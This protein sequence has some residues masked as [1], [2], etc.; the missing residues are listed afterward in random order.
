MEKL[1]KNYYKIITALGMLLCIL[2]I[3]TINTQPF[4]DF[5]YYDELAKQ[6]ANGGVLGDTYT[7]VGYSIALAFIYKIFGSSLITAKIFNLVL[8]FLNYMMIYSI[9]K[10]LDLHENKRIFIYTLFV[11]FPNNIFYNSIL[12]TEIFFTTIL[13]LVTLIYYSD[14]KYKYLLIGLLTGINTMVKPFFIVFFFV[15][16]IVE[17]AVR[18]RFVEIMKHTIIILIISI[19]TISPWIYRNTKLMGQYTF[20]SNNGGI[21]LYINN[22]SQ[23]HFGRWMPPENIENSLVNKKEYIKANMTEKNKMLSTS[24]KKWIISHPKQFIELGF[25]RLFNTYFFGDDISYSFNG[26]NLNKSYK[27]ILTVYTNNVRRLV[28]I[29]SIVV[30]LVYTIRLI[31]NLFNK[32]NIDSYNAYNLACFYMFACVYF[33]T[34]GQARYAFPSIFIMIYFFSCLVE[35]IAFKAKFYKHML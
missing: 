19:L 1:K 29:P 35:K 33:I 31:I 12:G 30:M 26:T 27:M 22:N 11:L 14:I 20:V 3:N 16:F 15:I 28:F 32:Q 7:S 6:I 5:A 10:K 34:E 21:V 17:L 4:S 9:L 25:K 13:L 23:N 2:W 8:T 18:I 24:A